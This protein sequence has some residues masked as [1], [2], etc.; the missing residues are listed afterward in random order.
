MPLKKSESD[1]NSEGAL[2]YRS[3][4]GQIEVDL[5]IQD[6]RDYSDI[7]IKLESLVSLL[8][9]NRGTPNQTLFLITGNSKDDLENL[10]LLIE[11][12]INEIHRDWAASGLHGWFYEANP[13]SPE[14]PILR[15]S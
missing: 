12:I 1:F 14:T 9:S 7:E 11:S 13:R 5:I 2:N 6:V 15:Y 3:V 10:R 4:K 8:W